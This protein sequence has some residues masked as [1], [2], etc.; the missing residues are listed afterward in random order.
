MSFC[1]CWVTCRSRASC[2][3]SR[4][5]V[6][7]AV[8]AA[9]GFALPGVDGAPIRVGLAGVAVAVAVAVLPGACL[10]RWTGRD[11]GVHAQ[12]QHSHSTVTA[13]SQRVDRA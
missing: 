5:V 2:V 7:G 10:K 9:D 12:S 4:S 1:S 8:D 6:D 3:R 13:Q 11:I